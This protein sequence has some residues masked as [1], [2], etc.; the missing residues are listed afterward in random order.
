MIDG[1]HVTE[2]RIGDRVRVRESIRSP[3][4]GRVGYVAGIDSGDVYGTH[5]VR[6]DNGL[7][8]R[9]HMFELEP[10]NERPVEL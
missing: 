5:L 4:A 10:I 2:L 3:Q 8:F 6:F 7:R 9:Y 1:G